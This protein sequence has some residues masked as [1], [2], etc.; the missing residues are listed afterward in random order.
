M[1]PIE[2]KLLELGQNT[3]MADPRI[4]DSL[5]EILTELARAERLHPVWPADP[6][7]QVAIMA[8]EAGEALRSANSYLHQGKS[9]I[10]AVQMR[11][12]LVQT[13]AMCLRCL[14]HLDIK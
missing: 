13:G 14:M 1:G 6:V 12:E 3:M 10:D 11:R 9:M 2:R 5:D 7:H 8:E 4:L